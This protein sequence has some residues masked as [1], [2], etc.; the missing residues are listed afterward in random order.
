MPELSEVEALRCVCQRRL[1]GRTITAVRSAAGTHGD[2]FNA[3]VF[4]AAKESMG[5]ALLAS[6][7]M[8]RRVV[9]AL[10]HGKILHLKLDGDTSVLVGLGMTG[11]LLVRGEAK[12]P[13]Q[14]KVADD[15]A[16]WLGADGAAVPLPKHTHLELDLEGLKV[17]YVD[18]RTFG[19]IRVRRNGTVSAVPPLSLLAPDAFLAL[20]TAA[21]LLERL[22]RS[23]GKTVKTALLDQEAA[24]SGVGNWIADEVC[25][26]AR[27]HPASLC[28]NLTVAHA[29]AL[30]GALR[31]VLDT[32]CAA[33]AN[34]TQFPGDWIFHVRMDNPAD[35]KTARKDAD[36]DAMSWCQKSASGRFTAVVLAK[37]KMAKKETTT[38]TPASSASPSAKKGKAK[39]VRSP[40][41]PKTTAKRA[42]RSR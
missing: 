42:R 8:G 41:T 28:G 14:Q 34:A 6:S 31:S 35:K 2:V 11:M 22:A 1:V 36:G 20:P 27:L 26:Q 19:S 37:Q 21:V 17:A 40:A 18:S 24:V 10:R 12:P 7:L 16:Q 5:E 3:R 9:A 32:A 25:Y 4:A 23:P 39:A 38:P 29:A 15:V 13:Y 33:N 30:R